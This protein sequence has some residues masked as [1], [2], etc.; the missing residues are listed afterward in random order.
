MAPKVA[1]LLWV[2]VMLCL[3]S[4]HIFEGVL[5]R[6]GVDGTHGGSPSVALPKCGLCVSEAHDQPSSR[7][8]IAKLFPGHSFASCDDPLSDSKRLIKWSKCRSKSLEFK[9]TRDI[10][11]LKGNRNFLCRFSKARE[12]PHSKGDCAINVNSVKTWAWVVVVPHSHPVLAQTRYL[13]GRAARP[14]I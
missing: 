6:W 3:A 11:P 14:P 9:I 7:L 12:S 4:E 1:H 13:S 2:C 8:R 5:W 10:I